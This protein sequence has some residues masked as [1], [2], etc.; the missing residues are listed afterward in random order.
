MNAASR[1]VERF[2]GTHSLARLLGVPTSTVQSWKQAGRIPA[3]RQP[4]ILAA[5][6]AADVNVT[7]ADFFEPEA[8]MG[9]GMWRP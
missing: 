9:D 1:L 3:K 6:R 5:G 7:P 8:L 4:A 2:G